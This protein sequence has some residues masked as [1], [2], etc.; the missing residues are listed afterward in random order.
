M[1]IKRGRATGLGGFHTILP[2][3]QIKEMNGTRSTPGK[4]ECIQEFS[5]ET[6]T[7]D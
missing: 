3:Q 5:Q 2:G 6:L 7:V 4:W 1:N